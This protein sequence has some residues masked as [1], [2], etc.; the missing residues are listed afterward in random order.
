MAANWLDNIIGVFDPVSKARRVRARAVSAVLEDHLRKYE[1]ASVG[2]R[3]KNWRTPSSSANTE[4]AQSL[5]ALRN[6]SRALVRDNCYAKRGISV[7]RENVVGTGIIM[8]VNGPSES[9]SRKIDS[10]FDSWAEETWIDYDGRHDIYGLQSL[11]ITAV[12]ESGEVLIRRRRPKSSDNIPVPLQ[13]QVLEADH[14]DGSINAEPAKGNT[15]IQGIEFDSNGQR[16]AYH[17][18]SDHPGDQNTYKKSTQSVR[19]PASDILHLYDC[20]R[21]GQVRGVPWLAPAII[22]LR[23]LDEFE[24]AQLIRQKIAAC[25]SAFVEDSE[26]A[27]ESNPIV[28]KPLVDRVE[29]GIIEHLPAGKKITFGIP[30]GVQG[31]KEFIT[32]HLMAIASAL[33]V[34]YEALT[35]DLSQV[36]FSS[37]RMGWLEFQRNITGW[38]QR[39]MV[40]QFLRPLW[41]WFVQAAS[42]AGYDPARLYP[43][44]TM[45]RREMI[46]PTKE[47]Q[48]TIKA[49]RAGLMTLPEAIKMYGYDAHKQLAE[50]AATNTEIDKLGLTLDSD[51]RRTNPS[52]EAIQNEGK[53]DEED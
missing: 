3:T 22:K 29:P 19:I 32:T 43:A 51:P 33:G 2:R 44:M 35:G 4:I 41:G 40:A 17:L 39:I 28:D 30:P 42:L 38:Q 53:P 23:D 45:P 52:G 7:I 10:L 50:I 11:A 37:A 20:S 47:I 24:D 46:D 31:Y 25:F 8:Q 6:R 49:I 27:S 12:A 13:L 9:K 16:V 1:G 5:P 15:I 21:A 26:F 34:T 36:N 14:L 18:T 48:A